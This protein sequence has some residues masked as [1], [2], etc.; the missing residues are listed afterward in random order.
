MANIVVYSAYYK[1][2]CMRGGDLYLEFENLA[3]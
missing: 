1:L 3:L 2:E